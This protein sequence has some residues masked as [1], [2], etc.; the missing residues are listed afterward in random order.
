[1]GFDTALLPDFAP[2]SAPIVNQLVSQ[3]RTARMPLHA[4]ANLR[5]A[6][7]GVRQTVYQEIDDLVP[8]NQFTI[9]RFRA[10]LQAVSPAG[11]EPTDQTFAL[12]RARGVLRMHRRGIPDPQ[13][14]A[15]ILIARRVTPPERR[16][17]WLP[18]EILPTEPAWWCWRQDGPGASMTPCP[19]PLPRDSPPSALLWTEWRGAAWLPGWHAAD[20]VALYVPQGEQAIEAALEGWQ[21]KLHADVQAA[22]RLLQGTEAGRIVVQQAWIAAARELITAHRRG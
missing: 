7:A 10:L 11:S 18:A 12:W 2:L 1:M 4:L 20:E 6:V 5:D 3:H 19:I 21:V 17:G 22:R 14:A 9:H 15:A 8:A 13:S 16:R